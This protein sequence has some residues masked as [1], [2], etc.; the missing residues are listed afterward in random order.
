MTRRLFLTPPSLPTETVARCLIIPSSKEWLGIFNAAILLTIKAHNYEQVNPT[1]MTTEEVVNI[2]YGIYEEYIRGDCNNMELR[3]TAGCNLQYRLS[4]EGIWLDV[5]GWVDNAANCFT[6]AQGVQGIQGIQGA[7]GVQGATGAQGVQGAQ[8]GQGAQGVQGV[9]GATGATG[10][11]ATL[12]AGMIIPFGGATLPEGWLDCDG[13]SVLR[14]TYPTLFSAIGTAW[15]SVDGT[16]FTLPDLR[17]RAPIGAGQGAGLT[18]R[19]LAATG[20]AETHDLDT[21][22]MPIHDHTI[23]SGTG[24]GGATQLQI[25][26]PIT[27]DTTWSGYAT[28]T[29]G[30]SEPHNNMQPFAVTKMIIST[31]DFSTVEALEFRIVDC[32]IEYRKSVAEGWVEVPGGDLSLCT[33]V[34]ATGATGAQ[35]ATGATGAQG[36]QGEAG[37][38]AQGCCGAEEP[39]AALDFDG[40]ICAVSIG[41]AEWYIRKSVSVMLYLKAGFEASHDILD[42]ITDMLD[43][44]PVFGPVVNNLIDLGVSM[45]L[46]GDFDD[47]VGHFLDPEF[48][49]FVTC[50]LYCGLKTRGGIALTEENLV[51]SADDMAGQAMLLLPGAPFATLYGQAFGLIVRA[52]GGE[53]SYKR[54]VVFSDE[55]SDNCNIICLDCPDTV[56]PQGDYFSIGYQDAT[57][58]VWSGDTSTGIVCEAVGARNTAIS[59]QS[60]VT[61]NT[62]ARELSKVWV[63][64]LVPT[65]TVIADVDITLTVNG[66][67]LIRTT[68]AF[69]QMRCSNNYRTYNIH[70]DVPP[71]VGATSAITINAPDDQA[72]DTHGVQGYEC[73]N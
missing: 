59:G 23:N 10:A 37:I 57:D 18:N 4:P 53:N 20:G 8:G 44:I 5:E 19:A 66:T 31:G 3:L 55:T 27:N 41:L 50:H 52:I 30:G 22:E 51:A 68:S 34:G 29:A 11:G 64:V 43:A 69:Y 71:T 65:A 49:D 1:D 60:T 16:H 62:G 47:M 39:E 58:Y 7:Q 67:A 48:L 15:G 24:P 33:E 40:M 26:A 32:L 61:W 9:Q 42:D 56:C 46:S 73:A 54:A 13:A 45:A 63:T 38:D 72:L 21:S 12:P 2:C 36:V 17:G 6:G 70:F 35:G 14:A 28:T 25:G